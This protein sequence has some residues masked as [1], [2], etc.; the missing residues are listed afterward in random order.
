MAVAVTSTLT[1]A[2]TAGRLLSGHAHL[3]LLMAGV[4]LPLAVL[5][6]A[7]ALHRWD[8]RAAE[9]VHHI[10][11]RA[12]DATS[13]AYRWRGPLRPGTLNRGDLVRLVPGRGDTVRV[14]EVLAA[15]DGP[16]LRRLTGRPEVPPLQL[17]NLLLALAL[18]A[19]TAAILLG[20]V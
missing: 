5:A 17:V 14:V 7:V 20:L 15:L 4:V 11:V 18:T 16:V 9:T 13:R 10:T 12:T 19:T 3:G 2:G 6:G 1:V 8:R